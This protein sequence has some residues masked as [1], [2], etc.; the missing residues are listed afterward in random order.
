MEHRV[1]DRSMD[2]GRHDEQAGQSV[3]GQPALVRS[4]GHPPDHSRPAGRP[5]AGRESPQGEDQEANER[6]ISEGV[7]E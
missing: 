1:D 3:R 5:E 6:D 4:A 7:T 2:D